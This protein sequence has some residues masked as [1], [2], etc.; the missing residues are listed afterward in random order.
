MKTYIQYN[1]VK[2]WHCEWCCVEVE[3]GRRCRYCGRTVRQRRRK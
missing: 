2:Y 3:K 1:G